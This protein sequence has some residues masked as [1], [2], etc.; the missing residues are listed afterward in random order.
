MKGLS[1]AASFLLYVFA[2]GCGLPGAR[3]TADRYFG[4]GRD[5]CWGRLGRL[6]G[7]EERIPMAELARF[8]ISE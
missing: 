2:D 8:G 7:W 1:T 5:I 3:L 6:I 4:W